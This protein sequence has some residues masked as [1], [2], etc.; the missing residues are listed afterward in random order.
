MH[1]TAND[2]VAFWGAVSPSTT[3]EI[4]RPEPDPVKSLQTML[5][6]VRATVG[7]ATPPIVS[8]VVAVAAPKLVP[9][10][11][12]VTRRSSWQPVMC[13]PVLLGSSHPAT[14][15]MAGCGR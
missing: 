6:G 3:N 2:G 9:T 14:V 1:G 15:V 10:M 5:V 4:A 8:V 13:S 7:H 11:V 12:K